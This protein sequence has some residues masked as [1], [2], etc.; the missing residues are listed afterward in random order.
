[1]NVAQVVQFVASGAWLLAIALV[2]LW[3]MRASRGQ[4]VKGFSTGVIIMLLVAA[5]LSAVGAGLVFIEPDELAVVITAGE[6]GIRPEALTA[7]IH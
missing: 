5:G 2:V 6:G 1:M 3:V 7:G 4:A